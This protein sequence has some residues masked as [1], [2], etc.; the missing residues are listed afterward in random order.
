MRRRAEHESAQGALS[1]HPHDNQLNAFIL[2]NL[3]DFTIGSTSRDP[4]LRR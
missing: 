2:R 1:L 4:F 3:Q